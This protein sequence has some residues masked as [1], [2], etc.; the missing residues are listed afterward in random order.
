M[1]RLVG[2]SLPGV[3]LWLSAGVGKVLSGGDPP[4]RLYSG[5]SLSVQALQRTDEIEQLMTSM[6]NRQVS[7]YSV[8]LYVV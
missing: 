7:E 2:V 8:L 5:A 1:V 3:P 4:P 6:Y